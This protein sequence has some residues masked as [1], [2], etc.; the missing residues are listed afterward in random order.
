MCN[1][2]GVIGSPS[3]ANRAVFQDMLCMG[4]RRGPHSTGVAAANRK[5]AHVVKDVGLPWDLLRGKDYNENIVGKN[6]PVLMGHNRWAT[7]GN[8][9]PG[10][11]HPFW[12]KNIIMMHNGTLEAESTLEHWDKIA[13]DSECLTWNVA[14]HGIT[15]TYKKLSGAWTMVWFDQATSLLNVITNGMRPFHF[16]KTAD[17]KSVFW[18]S[19]EWV[20]RM[21]AESR[22][23]ELGKICYNLTSHVMYQFFINKKG[24]VEY[25]TEELEGKRAAPFTYTGGYGRAY[26]SAMAEEGID[27]ENDLLSFQGSFERIGVDRTPGPNGQTTTI[28]NKWVPVVTKIANLPDR[29]LYQMR[30]EF[31]FGEAFLLF[32]T[33]AE[34]KVK[35]EEMAKT[36]MDGCIL[37]GC[38]L[39][40]EYRSALV[41]DPEVM[42]CGSCHQFS[43]LNTIPLV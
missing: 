41:I 22:G 12:H 37:C 4:V 8:I 25:K 17:E 15:D 42:A 16:I 39:V 11:A 5:Q 24:T 34:Y 14:E 20:I 13:T 19:E 6:W 10:N 33:E 18:A 27:E 43:N 7:I 2:V 32:K 28:G 3:R 40:T 1:V 21:A 23:V 38:D 31:P 36:E 35:I 30:K 9:V 29:S 26:Q